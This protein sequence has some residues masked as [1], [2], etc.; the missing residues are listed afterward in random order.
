MSSAELSAPRVYLFLHAHPSFFDKVLVREMRA[1]GATCRLI[2]LS[3]GDRIFRS[4][5]GAVDYRGRLRGWPRFLA[6]F[7][8]AERVTD[9]VYY[10]DQHPCHRLARAVARARG[11]RCFA[12]EFGYLRPDWITLEREGMGVLSHFPD[13]PDLIERLAATVDRRDRQVRYPYTFAAEAV[14]E[15][16][17]HL[18][19]VFIPFLYPHDVRDRLHHPLVEYLSYVPKL[20][21]RRR[22][23]EVAH[24]LIAQLTGGGVS[25][26]VVIMQMQGDYQVR[27]S[28]PYPRM[29]DLITT[30]L[31]SFVRCAPADHRLVFKMH[32]LENGL[33]NWPGVIRAEAAA[34]GCGERVDVI[35][36][37]DL[38]ALFRSCRGVV[39][40]NSTAGLTAL[41]HGV[42]V[43]ALG[44]AVYDMPRVTFQGPLD[45]FW[46]AP[47]PPRRATVDALVTVLAACIQV[48]GNFFT[49]EGRAAAAQEFTRRLLS[50]DVHNGGAFV[51]PPPR[52]EKARRLGVPGA[53]DT[54]HIDGRPPAR[55]GTG[56]P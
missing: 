11:V 7:I 55:V 12:Y 34:R 38:S 45:H 35:D 48:K 17:Y 24:R 41:T 43:K 54:V 36:G 44:I 32:P 53:D 29:R 47:T 5:T 37:G 9:I 25:Y 50:D 28:S 10:A 30:V 3:L 15:V 4:G 49:P 18:A 22:D 31:G 40:L 21:R 6:D 52:L 19:P 39:T 27:R 1:A 16:T 51:D 20:A 13:D 56:A 33:G 26:F 14:N 8:D 42:P 46:R 2:N 23:H